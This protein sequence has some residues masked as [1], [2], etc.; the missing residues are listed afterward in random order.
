VKIRARSL[1]GYQ[2]EL[3]ARGHRMLA[4]EPLENGGQ[5]AGPT[6]YELLLSSLA[7]CKLITMRMYARRKGW[8]LEE[9]EIEL[10]HSK[11]YARDCE[12]CRSDPNEQVDL[13]EERLVLTGPLS[14]AQRQRLAQIADRC[15]VHRSLTSETKIR[16]HVLSSP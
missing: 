9:V 7:A 1:Q 6:A 16:R 10:R 8:P 4:D 13:I 3:L 15:P 5:D 2:V 12:D 14:E 11:I